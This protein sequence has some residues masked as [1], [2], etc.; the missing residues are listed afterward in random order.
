MRTLAIIGAVASLLFSGCASYQ[1]GT[2]AELPYQSLSISAPRNLSS[3]PQIEGP[4]N[5]A[6]RKEIQRTGSIKLATQAGADAILEVTVLE[7]RREIAAVTSA[8]VGRGRKFELVADVEINLRKAGESGQ[9]FLEG[10]ELTIKQDIFTD[11][12]LVDAE[13]QAI[14]AISEQIA[15]RVAELIVDLW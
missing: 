4:L 1:L 15:R 8:D 10:R 11:S 14:P 13:Y 5:A 6:L 12:G 9:Y 2:P 7:I 3:L